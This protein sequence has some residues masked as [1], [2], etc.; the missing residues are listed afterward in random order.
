[1]CVC[2]CMLVFKHA[3][4]HVGGHACG[5]KPAC[6]VSTLPLPYISSSWSI[7]P[8]S[9]YVRVKGRGQLVGIGSSPSPLRCQG[10]N[11]RVSLLS[12][13]GLPASSSPYRAMLWDFLIKIR[14]R[15]IIAP[16]SHVI[17]VG[18][19]PGQ[20]NIEAHFHLQSSFSI[21]KTELY[22]WGVCLPVAVSPHGEIK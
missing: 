18:S 15:T 12:Q 2:E 21:L 6:S 11:F 9:H 4:A 22:H 20:R 3:C 1:M 7:S 8:R 17:C 16:T 5:S 19:D 13:W 14:R 10:L